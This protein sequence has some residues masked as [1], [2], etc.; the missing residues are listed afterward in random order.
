[1]TPEL[2]RAAARLYRVPATALPLPEPLTEGNVADAPQ[3]A[4]QL[5]GLG[6]P[7]FAHTKVGPGSSP[8]KARRSGTA[9]ATA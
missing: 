8:P 3:L 1:M 6:Y 4:H 9:S 5:S 7:G 2:A